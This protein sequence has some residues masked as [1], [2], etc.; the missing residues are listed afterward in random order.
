L[1]CAVDEVIAA[2]PDHSIGAKCCVRY[3]ICNFIGCARI[4]VA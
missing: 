1:S 3:Q 2:F 4:A